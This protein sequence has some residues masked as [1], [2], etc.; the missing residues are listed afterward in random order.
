V[1]IRLR[2]DQPPTGAVHIE[3]GCAGKTCASLDASR[4]IGA[5]PAGEWRTLKVKLACFRDVGADMTRVTSP[6]GF[7]TAGRLGLSIADVALVAN[8]GDAVCP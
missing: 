2:V 5:Q 3:L 7:R 8:T 4:M 6:L 1:A